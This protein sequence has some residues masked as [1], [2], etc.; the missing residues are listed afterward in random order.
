MAGRAHIAVLRD[1]FDP[2]NL[3]SFDDFTEEQKAKVGRAREAGIVNPVWAMQVALWAKL[4]Y[5]VLCAYLEQESDG[6]KNLWGSDDTWMRG[7]EL[8]PLGLDVVT[9]DTYKVYRLHR[10]EFGNQGVGPL[11]LTHPSFQDRGDELG[12]CWLP[13]PNM[14]AGAGWLGE[15]HDRGLD[16]HA[17][18]R[19]YNG[20]ESYAVHNDEL[21]AKWKGIIL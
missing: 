3:V 2:D 5:F 18:A 6:G 10:P 7:V 13:L 19:L 4:P 8:R 12:G 11:Q 20:S 9:E 21:R 16:W 17:I 1:D 15:Q 14:L